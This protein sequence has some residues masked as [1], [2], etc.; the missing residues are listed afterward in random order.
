MHNN[1][2]E[3]FT[4]EIDSVGSID[5]YGWGRYTEPHVLVGHPRKMFMRCFPT[6][7]AARKEF[8]D[9]FHDHPAFDC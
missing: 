4:Y 6:I 3:Y 2:F 7:E 9:A 5:V 8:P 1:E